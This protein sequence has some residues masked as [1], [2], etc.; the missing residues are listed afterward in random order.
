M[1]KVIVVLF[2]LFCTTRAFSQ[3]EV[4]LSPVALLF[5][6]VNTSIEYSDLKNKGFQLD[7]WGYDGGSLV[8]GTGKFYLNPSKG[9]DRFHVDI[10][11]GGRISNDN[12]TVGVGF[13]TGYKI[14]NPKGFLFEASLGLGRG[15]GGDKSR[16]IFL[17][18][19][20]LSVG[21][22]FKGKNVKD[23]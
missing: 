2:V 9:A 7:L 12:S 4:K 19:G 23:K 22:R 16:F 1:K 6:T 17:P 11:F 21:Y 8:Y 18:Y 10:F 14:V 13:A 5:E 20:S 3:L 15:W